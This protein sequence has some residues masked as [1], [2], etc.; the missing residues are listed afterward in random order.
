MSRLNCVGRPVFKLTHTDV[1]GTPVPK[2]LGPVDL[3]LPGNPV[4]LAGGEVFMSKR[5]RVGTQ[6]STLAASKIP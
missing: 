3:G 4:Q 1:S 5:Q 6:L 2:Q